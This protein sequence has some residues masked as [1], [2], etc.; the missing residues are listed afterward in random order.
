MSHMC[1]SFNISIPILVLMT[2]TPVALISSSVKAATVDSQMVYHDKN[3]PTPR[4]MDELKVRRALENKLVAGS[5]MS[6]GLSSDE[7]SAK[8]SSM[9][10]EQVHQ[11]ASL[12]D[13]IP[14]GGAGIV[15]ALLV[16][17]VLVLLII[18]LFER[19]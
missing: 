8:L 14:A 3:Q 4:E 11:M 12:A 6:H 18:L 19:V 9:S 16:I 7:V 17:L 13:K 2:F 15:V 5:L 1:R 10:D